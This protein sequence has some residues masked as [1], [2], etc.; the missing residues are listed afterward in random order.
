MQKIDLDPA[1]ELVGQATRFER[2]WSAERISRVLVG[3]G[4]QPTG[5]VTLPYPKRLLR[6]GLA[7]GIE[8]EDESVVLGVTLAQWSAGAESDAVVA[9]E[10]A[11]AIRECGELSSRLVAALGREY[12]VEA[13]GMVL[14]RDDYFFVHSVGWKVADVHLV[15][16]VEHVHPD[17][18]PVELCLYVVDAESA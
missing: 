16:G 7:L 6:E 14:D 9:D 3:S 1:C 8:S 13:E 17:D 12:E 18:T 11:A 2:P 15:I 10:Y 4:W 5:S